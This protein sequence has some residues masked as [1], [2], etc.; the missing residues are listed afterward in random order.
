MPVEVIEEAVAREPASLEHIISALPEEAQ[1][2]VVYR[3]PQETLTFFSVE[4]GMTVVD[5]TPG[6]VWYTGI[7][8]AYLGPDGKIIGADR[9]LSVWESFGSDYSPPA[10]LA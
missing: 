8:A 3:H 7:L 1:A 4:P 10:F 6:N 9:P 5:T 2:R